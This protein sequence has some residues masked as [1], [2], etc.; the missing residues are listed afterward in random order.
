MGRLPGKPPDTAEDESRDERYHET[1][2]PADTD[3]G[4]EEITDAR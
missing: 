2:G 1:T 4:D 3:G